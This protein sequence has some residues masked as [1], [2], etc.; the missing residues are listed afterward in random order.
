MQPQQLPTLL[1]VIDHLERSIYG[2]NKI[3]EE[4]LTDQELIELLQ[5]INSEYITTFASN[6][7]EARHLQLNHEVQNLIKSSPKKRTLTIR[8]NIVLQLNGVIFRFLETNSQLHPHAY[9]VLQSLQ[10]SLAIALIKDPPTILNPKQ[11]QRNLIETLVAAFKGYDQVAGRRALT[12]IEEAVKH[13]LKVLKSEPLEAS[14]YQIAEQEFSK[15]WKRYN[16]SYAIYEKSLITKEHHQAIQDDGRMRINREIATAINGYSIPADMLRFFREIWSKYLYVTY[17]RDGMESDAWKEGI[18]VISVV[19]QSLSVKDPHQMFQLYQGELGLALSVLNNGTESILNQDPQ[20]TKNVLE[21]LH[22]IPLQIIR[23]EEPDVPELQVLTQDKQEVATQPN[24]ADLKALDNIEIGDW[25]LIHIGEQ[26]TRGKLIHK[27]LDLGYCLFINYSGI[28]AARIE[29]AGLAEAMLNGKLERIDSNPIID[30]ALETALTY[31]NSQVERLKRR[32][33][34]KMEQDAI[35][36][37][38]I[39]AK[40]REQQ[41]A[42]LQAKERNLALQQERQLAIDKALVEV[43]MFQPGGWLELLTEDNVKQ[44]CKFG[45]K[46][47]NNQK[48]IFVDHLGQKVAAMLPDELAARIV[49]GSANIIDHGVAFEDTLQSLLL[50]RSEKINA[51]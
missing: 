5:T 22:A 38:E 45:L 16:Q 34:L 33:A 23:G 2:G 43:N 4:L 12:I 49:D 13:I 47:K 42:Q 18:N 21:Y 51:K 36:R 11:P 20:L 19:L 26:C 46:L 25:C 8:Q 40:E 7:L 32:I 41:A 6:F 44:V 39:A 1:A 10:T 17:L 29:I 50:D 14:A 3:N 15:F 24:S 27:D 28:K 9:T 37:E 31:I 35:R 48:M 30:R